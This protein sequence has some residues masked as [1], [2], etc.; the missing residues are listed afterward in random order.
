[1]MAKEYAKG[2]KPLV[3]KI[4]MRQRDFISVSHPDLQHFLAHF[5]K[6]F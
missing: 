5:N 4:K 1:M 3:L 6:G 2:L